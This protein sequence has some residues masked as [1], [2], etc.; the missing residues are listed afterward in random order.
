MFCWLRI[1]VWYV[2]AYTS[3]FSVLLHE[4][5]FTVELSAWTH[6]LVPPVRYACLILCDIMTTRYQKYLCVSCYN[7]LTCLLL[8]ES[9]SRNILSDT[10]NDSVFYMLEITRSVRL[11]SKI[12][13]NDF[14]LPDFIF[15][16]QNQR[17]PYT[18]IEFSVHSILTQLLS[19]QL[20]QCVFTALFMHLCSRFH[21]QPVRSPVTGTATKAPSVLSN[22]HSLT[23]ICP[24]IVK[25]FSTKRG[26][27]V[28][29]AHYVLHFRI[30]QE[31]TCKQS[32]CK[33]C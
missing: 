9:Y 24:S 6:R 12:W 20:N 23:N 33:K 19:F 5:W 18:V 8:R 2:C 14:F 7:E 10:K 22:G 28:T 21:A 4:V 25:R 32:A 26:W 29:D 13:L 15:W 16:G 3:N 1:V 11:L 27:V 17:S 30:P 31:V